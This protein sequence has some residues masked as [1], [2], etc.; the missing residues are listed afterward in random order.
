MLVRGQKK[1]EENEKLGIAEKR[2]KERRLKN[3]IEEMAL[4]AKGQKE[5][6][7]NVELG[8][9]EERN[10]ERKEMSVRGQ[11]KREENEK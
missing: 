4:I 5:R 3:K 10:K 11:K 8:G 7:E 9:T 6:E 2:N 1:R